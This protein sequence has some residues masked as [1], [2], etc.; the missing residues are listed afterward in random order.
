M[1]DTTPPNPAQE[2][3]APAK[4]N[5]PF[6][7][8]TFTLVENRLGRKMFRLKLREDGS[9]ELHM[10]KGSASN[11]SWQVTRT[12]PL[13]VAQKLKDSLDALGAFSW[14]EQYG[15]AAAPGALR[16]SLSTVF[17]EGV[18][19]VSS[20]GGSDT[21]RG[22]SDLLELLYQLDFP[23]P[24]GGGQVR[25]AAPTHAGMSAASLEIS[26]ALR[27]MGLDAQS[28]PAG[29]ADAMGELLNNLTSADALDALGD[30]RRNPQEL[31]RRMKDE[32][33]HMSPEEQNRLLDALSKTGTA[34]RSWWERFFRGE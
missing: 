6:E 30:M 28:L 7:K 22:Y 9:Y 29:A 14:D 25:A 31:Q 8:L 24:N 18:F 33:R 1:S 3:A 2:D 34:S 15:D 20:K 23:R 16:W 27:A 10:Q 13:E 12:V 11:P 26:N 19:S 32:F 17:K 21:P 5:P 4:R